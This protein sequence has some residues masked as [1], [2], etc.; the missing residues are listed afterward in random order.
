[1]TKTTYLQ[2]ARAYNDSDTL[3]CIARSAKNDESLHTTE[4]DEILTAVNNKQAA[5]RVSATQKRNPKRFHKVL[6]MVAV[7]LFLFAAG[8]TGIASPVCLVTVVNINARPENAYKRD[9]AAS[10]SQGL[11]MRLRPGPS[12]CELIPESPIN[13]EHGRRLAALSMVESQ[14]NDNAIGASGEISR[15]QIMPAV[16]RSYM[17]HDRPSA[18]PSNTTTAWHVAEWIMQDRC[19]AFETRFHRQPTD[20][21]FYILWAR[22]SWLLNSTPRRTL[23]NAM[24]ARAQNFSN[25]V[26]VTR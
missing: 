24:A 6:P 17:L 19:K 1:M 23:P 21:E 18:D 8:L 11:Q 3:E 5:N 22:P 2:L 15:F 10:F 20:Q 9:L 16:W 13:L 14:D 4:K 25:L 7:L 12:R 26:S